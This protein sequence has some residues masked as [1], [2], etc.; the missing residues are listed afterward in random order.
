MPKR[1]HTRKR[2]VK[3]DRIAIPMNSGYTVI[4]TRPPFNVARAVMAKAYELHP[5]PVPETEMVPMVTGV[6]Y[7]LPVAEDDEAKAQ[8]QKALEQAEAARESYLLKFAIEE[9]LIVE[10]YEGEDGQQRLVD[11]LQPQW[12]QV[13]KWG[14]IP[15]D[16]ADLPPWQQAVQLFVIS[17]IED[18]MAVT[19]NTLKALD[20]D[21]IDPEEITQ[22]GSFL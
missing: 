21:M 13:L 3:K 7:Q 10:D 20:A 15:D 14:T 18:Y 1:T 5:D 16:L 2:A 12:E 6:N 9:C 8:R 17:D 19:I 22:R 11:E 4:L